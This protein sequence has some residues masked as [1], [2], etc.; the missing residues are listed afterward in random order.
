MPLHAK[1]TW[2]IHPAESAEWLAEKLVGHSWCSCQGWSLGGYL[3]LNDQTS[4][5]G[6]FEVAIVKPPA[7]E[8]GEWWQVESITFGWLT[9]QVVLTQHWRET[10]K[11]ATP[12]ELSLAYVVNC[13][14]GAMD[15][16]K[17]G[18]VACP[19]QP[20]QIETPEQHGRCRHCA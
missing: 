10:G 17:E 16:G 18:G 1:R 2:V 4:E 19:C 11:R 9:S 13:T 12:Y 6:A 3:F 14:S 7:E 20:C 8:G 5:D 15:P